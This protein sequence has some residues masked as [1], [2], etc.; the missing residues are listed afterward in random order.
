MISVLKCEVWNLKYEIFNLESGFENLKCGILN[1][2]AH[3]RSPEYE[4][5]G[6]ISPMWNWRSLDCIRSRRRPDSSSFSQ[7]A[8]ASHLFLLSPQLHK[9]HQM[10]RAFY[11]RSYTSF[12]ELT[13]AVLFSLQSGRAA[14]DHAANRDRE[15]VESAG[16]LAL[17]GKCWVTEPIQAPIHSAWQLEQP[18]TWFL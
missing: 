18:Q 10:H 2:D 17:V 7:I 15:Q 9:Y 16:C 11:P 5:R 12:P 3:I 8:Q 4:I 13:P 6:L 1:L 14:L